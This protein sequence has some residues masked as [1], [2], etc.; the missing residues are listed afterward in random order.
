MKRFDAKN[1]SL[2]YFLLRRVRSKSENFII[3]SHRGTKAP[4]LEV[5][6][7]FVSLFMEVTEAASDEVVAFVFSSVD[8]LEQSFPSDLALVVI[9]HE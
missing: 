5:L 7:E 2:F 9:A 8:V 4:I 1:P 3:V 6:L